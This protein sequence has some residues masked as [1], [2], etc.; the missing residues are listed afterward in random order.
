GVRSQSQAI[1]MLIRMWVNEFGPVNVLEQTMEWATATNL[2]RGPTATPPSDSSA[3][4]RAVIA[5]AS[6]A[7]PVAEKQERQQVT[8]AKP[9][10]APAPAAR[11]SPPSDDIHDMFRQ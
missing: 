6:P 11:R 4:P 9:D 8:A 10:P 1:V 5:E 7:H 3:A 2:K